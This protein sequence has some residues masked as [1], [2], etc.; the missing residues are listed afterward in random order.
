MRRRDTLELRRNASWL[1]LAHIRRHSGSSRQSEL[2][3]SNLF[4]DLYSR[5][6]SAPSNSSD[7]LL[8]G[9]LMGMLEVI[10]IPYIITHI[11]CK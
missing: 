7:I 4:Q 9:I 6:T 5:L 2:S 8:T 11:K 10:I 1:R 3:L